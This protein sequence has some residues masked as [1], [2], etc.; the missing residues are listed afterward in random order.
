[1][2]DIRRELTDR[3]LHCGRMI[4]G[5]KRAPDGHVCV[6]NA[7]IIAKSQGKVWFGDLDLTTEGSL[8][9]E[10]ANVIGEPL[11][12]LREMDCRFDTESDDVN[13]LISRAVWN[14]TM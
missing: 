13:L 3:K 5:C 4:S 9:K 2:K 1:M 10:V 12:V 14:T 11:Y 7:N 6:W 8:L